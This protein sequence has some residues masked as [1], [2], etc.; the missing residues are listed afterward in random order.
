[1]V[2]KGNPKGIKDWNDLVREDVRNVV[3]NPKTSGNGRYT[4]LAAWAYAERKFNHDQTK[5][6]QFVGQLFRNV[7][8]LDAGG[9]GATTTFVQNGI[10]D[11]L[12]T[13]ESEV[14]QIAKVFSPDQFQVVVPSLSIVADVPVAVV[15]RVVVR[16]GSGKEADEY[17]RY[18]WSEEGQKLIAKNYF[19]PR[20][21]SAP[22]AAKIALVQVEKDFGGWAKAQ[23]THFDDGALYDQIYKP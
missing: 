11:V 21:G 9:R 5:V 17:L 14:F 22:W 4:Y 16:R 6:K 3:P 15:D 13:F 1:L 8:V 7:P 23:K 20:Q 12:L 10:G 19:R 18:L 2:R